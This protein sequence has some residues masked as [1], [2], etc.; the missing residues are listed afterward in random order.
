M[1][2]LGGSNH[3]PP[4][5]Q[6]TIFCN[7][8]NVMKLRIVMIA[9]AVFVAAGLYFHFRYKVLEDNFPSV[10]KTNLTPELTEFINW[11]GPMWRMHL[12]KS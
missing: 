8:E 1:V 9:V 10:A 3:A 7:G 12:K 11:Y 4:T 2:P 5:L 6:G